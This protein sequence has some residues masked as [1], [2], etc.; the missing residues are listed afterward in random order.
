MLADRGGPSQ[1][2]AF[3][4]EAAKIA[5]GKSDVD[6]RIFKPRVGGFLAVG[7]APHADWV[8]LG[9]PLMHSLTFAKEIQ[10]VDQHQVNSAAI[11]G[12]VTMDDAAIAR[13]RQLGINVAE[14]MGKP[15]E[16]LEYKGDDPGMCPV[17]HCNAMIIR[18]ES[19]VECAVCGIQ[20]ELTQVD[21]KIE[22]TFTEEEQATSRLTLSGKR[23]HFFEIMDVQQQFDKDKA[24]VRNRTKK[25]RGYA[26]TWKN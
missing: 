4:I 5:G 8:S 15:K 17:C 16:E 9:L 25:Y 2:Q 23:D 10:I 24:E 18:R 3:I 1:D 14:A 22:I 13:A 7:G 20:G 12:Q 19:P 26:P 21:G 6:Q 11:V